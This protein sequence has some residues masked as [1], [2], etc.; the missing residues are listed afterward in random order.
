ME[1]DF[2]AAIPPVPPF[3]VGVSIKLAPVGPNIHTLALATQNRVF[4][5]SCQQPPSPAQ[6]VAL[7]KILETQ[8]L[9][10]F[11]LPNTITLLAHALGSDVSGYDLSTLKNKD[12]VTP[13]DFLN[14]R[15]VSV[16]ARSI[17]ERWDGSI[18]S[19]S[20]AD[21]TGKLEPDYAIRAWFSAMYVT[22]TPL[23]FFDLPTP[24]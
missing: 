2:R 20:D 8:Y 19:R 3:A 22:L 13:G 14:S 18:L 21:S 4:C 17:N 12:I 24:P 5:L 9:V 23:S 6:K 11:E 10:G 1:V 7:Q 15:N 16:S